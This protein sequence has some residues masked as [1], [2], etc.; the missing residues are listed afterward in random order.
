VTRTNLTSVYDEKTTSF[1]SSPPAPA[2]FPDHEEVVTVWRRRSGLHCAIAIHSTVRG[3]SLGGSRFRAYPTLDA[4][5]ADVSNLA[6]AMTYKAAVAGLPFGGGKSVLIGD[7]AVIKTKE[8]WID[9][10]EVLN[11]LDGRYITAED[12]G[13]TMADMDGLKELTPF[14]AGTS[15]EKGGSGD[16]SPM[17]AVGI[18]SGMEATSSKLWGTRDL[19]GK[20]V[21]VSGLGKVGSTLAQLLIDQGCRLTI[22]DVSDSAIKRLS[23]RPGVEVTTPQAIHRTE[24]DIFAPCALGGVINRTTVTELRCQAVVGAANNQLASPD[25]AERLSDR[26]VLYVPDFVVNAG[27]IIN[28]AHE[29]LGYD[30]KR[31]RAHVEE[32]YDTTLN[33]LDRAE[34]E[35]IPPLA[36]AMAIARERLLDPSS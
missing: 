19:S 31:A 7:P 22:T 35:A 15:I 18:F 25:M 6:E 5:I 9:Y 26:G 10:A 27:G 3:P 1:E 24:C 20:R 21:A 8:L 17:T 13:A 14:V 32:I 11:S 28:I 23:D 36:A 16:P 2:L 30:E 29:Y 12:V 34:S 33:I 4:A